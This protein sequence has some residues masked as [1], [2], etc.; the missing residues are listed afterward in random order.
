MID[1]HVIIFFFWLVTGFFCNRQS[2][3]WKRGKTNKKNV[4]KKVRSR[5]SPQSGFLLFLFCASVYLIEDKKSK[6]KRIFHKVFFP[7]PLK[8]N[9]YI[10]KGEKRF[11]FR[12]LT[13]FRN[14]STFFANSCFRFFLTSW[15]SF[16]LALV[17]KQIFCQLFFFCTLI[18][19]WAC[20]FGLR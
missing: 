2:T 4:W 14:S 18:F 15:K 6:N 1:E 12:S 3:R 8:A 20:F 10:N 11:D 17:W 16:I 7:S 19:M 5:G 13:C 9:R